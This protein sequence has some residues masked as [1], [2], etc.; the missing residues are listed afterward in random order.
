MAR[1]RVRQ[2][3]GEDLAVWQARQRV[4]ANAMLE[5]DPLG[6]VARRRVPAI[7]VCC[8]A[9]Q[10]P[11]PAAIAMAVACE[12][13]DDAA[14][15]V[16]LALAALGSGGALAGAERRGAIVRMQKVEQR[17]ADEG[18]RVPAEDTLAGRVYGKEAALVVE[19]REH[20]AG[21]QEKLLERRRIEFAQRAIPW[22]GQ[23]GGDLGYQPERHD[24]G[25]GGFLAAA[26]ND[27]PAAAQDP[28]PSDIDTPPRELE[29]P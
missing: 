24:E 18:L 16:R 22:L 2:L 13:L 29:A 10:Q 1:E 20:A 5:L 4:A 21:V 27:S 26:A 6:D 9:P 14:M 11:A 28:R 17:L 25:G 19:D 23:P 3:G 7:A 15:L 8:A 12:Q